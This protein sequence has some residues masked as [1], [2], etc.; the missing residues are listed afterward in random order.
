MFRPD[1]CMTFSCRTYEVCL[2][3]VR[4]CQVEVVILVTISIACLVNTVV[5]LVASAD[6]DA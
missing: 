5:T 3:N 6:Y 1:R 2:L 4:T